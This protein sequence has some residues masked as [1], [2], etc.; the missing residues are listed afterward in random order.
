ML[1]I[2]SAAQ[3]PPTESANTIQPVLEVGPRHTN[4]MRRQVRSTSGTSTL[5]T[6]PSDKDFFLTYAMLS[7][8]KDATS[9]NVEIPLLIVQ[10]GAS[11]RVI[12]INSQTTTAESR[13]IIVT[14]PYP[15]KCDKAS[16]I[17]FITTF[18]AGA[19]VCNGVIGG[20]ILE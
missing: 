18:T 10:D 3:A 7:Y 9:D 20:F 14:F 12:Q 1:G 13:T 15:V 19:L 16:A 11:I 2:Q 5:Y 8:S 4:V 17:T 6:T